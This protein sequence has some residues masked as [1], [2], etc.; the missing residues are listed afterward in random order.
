MLCLK[1]SNIIERYFVLV[2]TPSRMIGGCFCQAISSISEFVKVHN[3]Y[4][5][6]INNYVLT[7][8]SNPNQLLIFSLPQRT[9]SKVGNYTE[10]RSQFAVHV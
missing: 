4:H 10:K 8:A 5:N 9:S 2:C 7:Q 3:C 6:K 1:L